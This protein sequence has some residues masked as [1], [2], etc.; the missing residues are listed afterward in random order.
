MP[1]S[2]VTTRSMSAPSPASLVSRS[3]YPRSRWKTRSSSVV[4]VGAQSR[5]DECRAAANVGDA[6]AR[7]VQPR[8]TVDH[9]A[10]SVDRDVRAHLLQELDV[11]KSVL[12]QGFAD[13]ARA[14]RLGHQR[15][16][17]RL[18][19]GGKPGMRPRGHV[20]AAQV[21]ARHAHMIRAFDD[22]AS[23][24]AQF[25]E[26]PAQVARSHVLDDDVAVRRRGRDHVRAGL[27]VVGGDVVRR[28]VQQS[29]A[30]LD[31]DQLGADAGDVRAH[32]D[33]A[34]RQV[35]H[36]RLARGVADHGD[37]LGEHRRHHQVL[38]SRDRRHVER[39]ART[40][41]PPRAR[42]VATL[43]LLDLGAHEAQAL[44]VLLDAA[45]ADVIA[46]GLGDARLPRPRH[47]RAEQ[48]E[49]AAHPPAQ[50]SDPPRWFATRRRAAARCWCRDAPP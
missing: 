13:H 23:R 36:V 41:Q 31:D 32:A 45:H 4:P 38:G 42:H 3:S 30:A 35:V 24:R 50:A 22:V 44:E 6:H 20:D 2:S 8:R 34:A 1:G 33:Q 47:Q 5:D 49:R 12:V 17:L 19:V 9:R 27:D 7:A 28:P 15:A 11:A 46:P 29:T 48:Q 26:E 14:S 16:E 43:A 18:H 10:A 25:A 37:A 40:V 21:R 39:D